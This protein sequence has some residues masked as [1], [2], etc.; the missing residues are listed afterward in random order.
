MAAIFLNTNLVLLKLPVVKK[1][2]LILFIS[3]A[4]INI[5][6]QLPT[7]D[8]AQAAAN[9][10]NQKVI[11]YP[12]PP[13]S[14]Y[15]QQ[16]VD[17]YKK[18]NEKFLQ[19]NFKGAKKDYTKAIEA[20]TKFIDAYISRGRLKHNELHD[21]LGAIEDYNKAI[22]LNPRYANAYFYRA[23][24]Y[25]NLQNFTLACADWQKAADLGYADAKTSISKHCK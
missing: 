20:N 12:L 18:G 15:G 1:H 11:N 24:A 4:C 14:N 2:F 16:A 6:G 23:N 8:Y 19:K 9:D 3:M 13:I 7:N 21:D 17:Y 22:D 5:Y 10:Y 25:R